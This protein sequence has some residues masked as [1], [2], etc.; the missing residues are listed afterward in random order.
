MFNFF[1][2]IVSFAFLFI[3][4]YVVLIC[5]WGDYAP[6]SFK[7][8]LQYKLGSYGHMYSRMQEIKT[9]KDIDVLFL[10][11]S[12][13]Y[14]GFD[15][16]IFK[17]DGFKVFNLGSSAQTPIQTELLLK[18]YLD[19]LSP[20]IVVFEVNPFSF[21][22][23]GVESSL[24]LFA[25]DKND[26]YS[27][28]NAVRINHIKTYNVLIYSFY[29]ELFNMNKK[30][31]EQKVKNEDTYVVNGY[32]EKKMRYFVDKPIQKLQSNI[33]KK[34]ISAFE[35]ILTKL[36]NEGIEYYLVQAPITKSRYLKITGT[37]DF[38]DLMK[39]KGT[40]YNFN[41]ILNLT[42]SLHFYDS[43]HLNQEGVKIFNNDLIQR[44]LKKI[45]YL[46]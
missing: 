1:K 29:R 21:S 22:S 33:S 32:V 46:F 5:V 8:N 14:R 17:N 43:H 23:D 30:F 11:S 26:L 45:N 38:D 34:Q 13:T 18:R 20:K 24:D 15:T 16:R 2:S 12:H 41:Y 6:L 42:D 35:N 25:N 31:V 40:Y 7:K 28:I 44:I 19:S 36:K 3:I 37:K 39:D 10:G 27:I 4:F 9:V